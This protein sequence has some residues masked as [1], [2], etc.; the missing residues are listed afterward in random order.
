MKKKNVIQKIQYVENKKILFSMHRKIAAIPFSF[1]LYCVSLFFSLPISPL[2]PTLLKAEY[3]SADI[4]LLCGNSPFLPPSV[5]LESSRQ[6]DDD[7]FF[8]ISGNCF[9]SPS[10]TFECSCEYVE[11]LLS[12]E[13]LPCL[14]LKLASLFPS[15]S[16]L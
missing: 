7:A 4:V 9:F 3:P 2:A 15:P 11:D 12:C 16:F 14:L 8:F 13:F 10:T 1:W 5:A 6:Y